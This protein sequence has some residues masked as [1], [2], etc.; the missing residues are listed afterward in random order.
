MKE[1]IIQL[2]I[3]GIIVLSWST[4]WCLCVEP[5]DSTGPK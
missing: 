5:K 3:V 2:I 1:E 4:W